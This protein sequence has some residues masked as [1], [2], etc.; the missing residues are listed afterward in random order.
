MKTQAGTGGRGGAAGCWCAPPAW[1]SPQLPPPPPP[2]S[3]RV[4]KQT[5]RFSQP[6]AALLKHLSELTCFQEGSHLQELFSISAKCIFTLLGV[7]FPK[8]PWKFL[9]SCA[10]RHGGAFLH[11]PRL[12]LGLDAPLW[13]SDANIRRFVLIQTLSEVI[14]LPPPAVLMYLYKCDSN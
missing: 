7:N 4:R 2:T 6:P 1:C 9:N 10:L 3:L 12:V 8:V 14:Y 13:G 11:H 5:W